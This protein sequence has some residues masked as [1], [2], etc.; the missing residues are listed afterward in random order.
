MRT[1]LAPGLF[2]FDVVRP[3]GAGGLGRVDDIVVRESNCDIAVGTH[4]ARKRLNDKWQEHQDMCVRFEREIDAGKRMDH[5]A[6]VRVVGENVTEGPERFYCMRLY[7]TSLRQ[8]VAGR[9]SPIPVAQIASFGFGIA[10][11]L[12]YAHSLGFIHRD[13]K[14]DNILLRR[15][16][17]LLRP[18]YHPVIADWGLGRF[19]HQYS[20]V[21]AQFSLAGMGT[22]RYCA[23]EQWYQQEADARVDTYS[24]GITLAELVLLK[25]PEL[26]F[27]G[28]GVAVTYGD[29]ATTAQA[30]LC[31]LIRRMT[32]VSPDGR[33]G[34]M[35]DVA[36]ELREIAAHG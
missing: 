22:E 26:R 32:A 25:P 8:L 30:A 14:P 15:D 10:D 24:L 34:T 27:I 29:R 5:P 11:A 1:N 18:V 12:A 6:I 33:P 21:L 17:S 35:T 28:S 20:V 4:L 19:V 16:G 36:A 23:Y 3:L 31:D 7:P 9:R 2:L 13:L